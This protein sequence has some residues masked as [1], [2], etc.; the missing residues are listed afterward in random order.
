MSRVKIWHGED[1]VVQTVITDPGFI[2]TMCY[3]NVLAV[4]GRIFDNVMQVQFEDSENKNN[5]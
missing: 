1:T 5:E 4:D 3:L 2:D